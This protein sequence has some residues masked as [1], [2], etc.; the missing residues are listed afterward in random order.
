[1]EAHFREAE[2]A[3][4]SDDSFG[5]SGSSEVFPTPDAPAASPAPDFPKLVA[6]EIPFLRRKVRRWKRDPDEAEDLVQ[7][8][9][10]RALA[11]AHS[12]QPG[13]D[14]RAWLFTIMRNQLYA[15]ATRSAELLKSLAAEPPEASCRPVTHVRLELRDVGGALRRLPAKQ[16]LAIMLVAVEGKSYEEGAHAMAISVDAVRCHLARGR[17]R[18]RQ[19]V[20]GTA[21]PAPLLR[22]AAGS[23]PAPAPGWRRA[24]LAR[25]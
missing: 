1:M 17:Q 19:L 13:S 3:A 15:S 16:R 24:E 5:G 9:L 11:G 12:W 6:S 18:L 20:D 23:R 4:S 8:T 21:A 7:E 14:L 2:L 22:R 25:G 10:L